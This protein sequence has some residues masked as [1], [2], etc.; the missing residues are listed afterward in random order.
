[1]F[2]LEVFDS[3]QRINRS[4]WVGKG[5]EEIPYSHVARSC[6]GSSMSGAFQSGGLRWMATVPEGLFSNCKLS[7]YFSSMP[8]G[9]S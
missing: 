8:K 4:Q 5:Q 6:G 2:Q 1:M 7:V 9:R 3:C